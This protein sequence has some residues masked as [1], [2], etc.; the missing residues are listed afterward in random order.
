MA[1]ACGA[2]PRASNEY[3]CGTQDLTLFRRGARKYISVKPNG[4]DRLA[5]PELDLSVAI[6]DGWARFWY[7]DEMLQLSP[8][9]Q[10]SLDK[11]AEE[12]RVT[13]EKLRLANER[14][15]RLMAQLRALGIEPDL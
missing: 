8:D 12:L 10:R 15:Q 9:L 3:R 11:M 14:E 1:V 5:I 6:H 4:G 7:R 2:A 13:K